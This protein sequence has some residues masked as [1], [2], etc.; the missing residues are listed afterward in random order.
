MNNNK[1]LNAKLFDAC[2]AEKADFDLIE[3][4]LDK[5]ADPLVI[6]NEYDDAV[7]EELFCSA[8][9]FMSSG[10]ETPFLDSRVPELV[11]LFIKHG[12]DINRVP[13]LPED[14]CVSPLWSMAF[15]CTPNA[16]K[17]LKILL[18]SGLKAPELDEF[19]DHF[20]M[21][22]GYVSG[23]LPGYDYHNYL[24]CGFKMIMLAAS[25]KEALESSEYLRKTIG[26]NSHNKD[27]NYDLNRFRNYDD[28]TYDI[29]KS[30]CTNLRFG[31][32]NATVIIKEKESGD[33][34][35][36]FFL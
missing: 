35:W 33:E 17:T 29:D 34:V 15:W 11:K 14:S 26:L 4:L 12:M 20:T 30:T 31:L 28:Y 18:D 2:T 3:E 36:R 27:N 16:I 5:G 1:G 19:I 22:A 25:Y 7:L 32:G 8:S 6:F 21:D 9:D 24:V 10:F 13:A 23:D